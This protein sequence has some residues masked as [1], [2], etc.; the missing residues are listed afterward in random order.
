LSAAAFFDFNT[1]FGGG[2]ITNL[3][4][5]TT[6]K[7]FAFGIVDVTEIVV[8][9]PEVDVCSFAGKGL[10]GAFLIAAFL[11][12]FGLI[13]LG[14]RVAAFFAIFLAAGFLGGLFLA[15]FLAAAFTGFFADVFVLFFADFLNNFLIAT[16][17]PEG[18][19]VM[20]WPK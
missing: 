1:G 7:A 4:S 13:I 15:T 11:A 18:A 8:E 9:D 10:P 14:D 2:S 12:N 6:G 20:A 3:R 17:P 16:L 5:S 19:K